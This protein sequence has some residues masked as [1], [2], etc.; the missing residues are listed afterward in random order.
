M[1]VVVILGVRLY[2][3]ICA[4]VCKPVCVCVCV[5]A[6]VRECMY[7][8]S[9]NSRCAHVCIC[10]CD[11]V[12]PCVYVGVCARAHSVCVFVDRGVPDYLYLHVYA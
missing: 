7:V 5:C 11:G 2:V 4:T 3:H 9:S 8:R 10:M 1:Y 12:Q 6:R